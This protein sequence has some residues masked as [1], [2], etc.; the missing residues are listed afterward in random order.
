MSEGL[1]PVVTAHR[2]SDIS[3]L[4]ITLIVLLLCCKGRCQTKPPFHYT[5]RTAAFQ[6]TRSYRSKNISQSYPPPP[7]PQHNYSTG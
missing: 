3:P 6:N 5:R 4:K 2:R 1:L 7:P